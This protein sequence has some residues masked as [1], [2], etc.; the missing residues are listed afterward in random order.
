MEEHV[1]F[2]CRAV[3]AQLYNIGKI[4]NYL[5]QQ[6]TEKLINALVHSRT[7]YCNALLIGLPK[8]LIRKL[9]LVQTTATRVLC[10]FSK[11]DHSTPVLVTSLVVVEFRIKYKVRLLIHYTTMDQ[12]ICR[13]CSLLEASITVECPRM[14][15]NLTQRKTLGDRAFK[16]AAPKLWNSLPKD[17]RSCNNVSIL[18]AN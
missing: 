7:D 15:L 6:S 13:R 8:Y 11:Y 2:K 5:D 9:Q 18:R 14:I 4:R 12:N 16:V 1:K 3:Y 17:V 10:R